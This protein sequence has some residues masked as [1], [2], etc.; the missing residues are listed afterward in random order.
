[1]F[2]GDVRGKAISRHPLPAE[3]AEG[4]AGRDVDALHSPNSMSG[5]LFARQAQAGVQAPVVGKR[6]SITRHGWKARSPLLIINHRNRR[7]DRSPRTAC[8]LQSPRI[9][10]ASGV[11]LS[12]VSRCM[13]APKSV[14]ARPSR[15]M[16]APCSERRGSSDRFAV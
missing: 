11:S 4:L 10:L 1:M 14:A 13:R 3:P 15:G 2:L 9:C 5:S 7:R 16:N 12:N 6:I 8:E